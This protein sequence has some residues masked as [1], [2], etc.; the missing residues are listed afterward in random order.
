MKFLLMDFDRA[1]LKR[2][3]HHQKQGKK[4]PEKL[5]FLY[6]FSLLSRSFCFV[7]FISFSSF[8]RYLRKKKHFFLIRTCICKASLFETFK[9]LVGSIPVWKLPSS[10]RLVQLVVHGTLLKLITELL[11]M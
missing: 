1:L 6:N 10:L 2:T 5:R 7:H 4:R 8:Q 3:S 11:C 9:A